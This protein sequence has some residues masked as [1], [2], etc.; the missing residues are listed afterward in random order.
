MGLAI[1]K[2]KKKKRNQ[3]QKNPQKT[4]VS[5]AA[6]LSSKSTVFYMS[7]NVTDITMSLNLLAQLQILF[8][9]RKTLEGG[10]TSP[11]TSSS[12]P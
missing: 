11:T 4:A 10:G 8:M 12:S 7:I 5:D 1:I 3:T 2:R 9:V 6:R